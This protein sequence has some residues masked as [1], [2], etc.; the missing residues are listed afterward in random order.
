M[1]WFWVVVMVVIIGTA[2]VIAAG[3]GDALADVYEDR[4]DVTVE[5][6]PLTAADVAKVR[7]TTAVRGYRMDEVDAFVA[8][9]DAD[10]RARA[11]GRDAAAVSV[12]GGPRQGAGDGIEQPTDDN[13]ASGTTA[14]S[15]SH[16]DTQA[17][18]G[19]RAGTYSEL[20]DTDPQT[21]DGSHRADRDLVGPPEASTD[22]DDQDVSR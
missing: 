6:G 17:P 10:L 16:Q 21:V 8:R 22:E 13:P 18:R 15:V 5:R 20:V 14:T 7:F 19:R 11:D 3:R 2:A 9:I 12:A 4:P 1:I